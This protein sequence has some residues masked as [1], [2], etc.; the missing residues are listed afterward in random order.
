MTITASLV[1]FAVFWF[2]ILFVVLPLN[3]KTQGEAGENSYGTPSSAPI[4]ANI[5]KKMFLVTICT[6]IIWIISMILIYLIFLI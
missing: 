5:K 1:L 2:L 3:I 4:K 6:L